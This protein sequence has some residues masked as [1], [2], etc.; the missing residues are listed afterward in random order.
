MHNGQ[1]KLLIN[2]QKMKEAYFSKQERVRYVLAH[3]IT[4]PHIR[5]KV[6]K[7]PQIKKV[8]RTLITKVYGN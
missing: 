3:E 7:N 4:L 6:L 5:E 2:E 8:Y 1:K